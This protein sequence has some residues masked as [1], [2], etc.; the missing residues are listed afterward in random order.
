MLSCRDIVERASEY[1][2]ADLPWRV[3][4]QV[5]LHL[6]MCAICREYLRQMRLVVA[7]LRQVPPDEPPAAPSAEVL[8]TFRGS[9][10]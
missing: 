8:E 7:T 3:R 5:R 9:R 10:R 4:L 2:D 1:L 6:W